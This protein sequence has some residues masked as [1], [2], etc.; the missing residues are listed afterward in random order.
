MTG[1][2]VHIV[3]DDGQL[4]EALAAKAEHAGFLV[5]AHAT[6]EAFLAHRLG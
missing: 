4:R 2:A 1:A 5:R 3:D 6:A